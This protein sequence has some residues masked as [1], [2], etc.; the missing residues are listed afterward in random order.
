MENETAT[1]DVTTIKPGDT[2]TFTY[3][4]DSD[5]G[6][7]GYHQNPEVVQWL[8]GVDIAETWRIR[9]GVRGGEDE[10]EDQADGGMQGYFPRREI[11]V[12][13][14]VVTNN[15]DGD[16]WAY[17]TVRLG[18]PSCRA[19]ETAE[20]FAVVPAGELFEFHLLTSKGIEVRFFHEHS[21]SEKLIGEFKV[22]H[23]E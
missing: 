9:E 1:L 16:D 23:K 21:M 11:L 15:S 17:I 6:S 19:G 12:T 10:D 13:G 2:V 14:E 3:L 20:P 7:D 18:E 5:P 4:A 8:Y 22:T